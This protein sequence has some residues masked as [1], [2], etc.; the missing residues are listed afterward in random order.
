VTERHGRELL[1]ELCGETVAMTRKFW[2][3]GPT[4][5]RASWA[6][7]DAILILL[8]DG[9][10]AAEQTVSE[11]GHADE[12]IAFRSAYHEAMNDRMIALVE[13]VTDRSVRAAL[14]ADHTNPDITALVFVL[15]PEDLA[16]S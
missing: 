4:K 14:S 2:G 13:R 12:V 10:T 9:F 11:A 7:P 3:K 15:E 5:C 16:A 8:S 1:G 6:G